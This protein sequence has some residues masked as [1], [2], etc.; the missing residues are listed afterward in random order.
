[1]TGIRRVS[2]LGTTGESTYVDGS[3][4]AV[5]IAANA[6]TQDKLS[7]DV[8]LSGMRNVLINGDM[9]I[10]QRSTSVAI[11]T[12]GYTADRWYHQSYNGAVISQQPT[13]DSTRLPSTRY[14]A[15]VLRNT[16]ATAVN[17]MYFTQSMETSQSVKLAGQTATLSFWARAGAGITSS[18]FTAS[19][20]YGTGTDQNVIAG[21]TGQATAFTNNVTLTTTWQKFTSTGAVP[22]TATEVAFVCGY[23]PVGTAPANDYFEITNVQLEVGPQPTPFEQR[24][25]GME[26]ALCQRY[27]YQ[28]QEGGF[29]RL[30]VV[31]AATTSREAPFFFPVTMRATPTVTITGGTVY[32]FS[33]GASHTPSSTTATGLTPQGGFQISSGM[34]AGT[35]G[36]TCALDAFLIKASA[37]L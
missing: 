8:P 20:I 1:M 28:L 17:F 19:I 7:T 11:A 22:T 21:Y 35:A 5:D 26:L 2:Q 3:I 13:S 10:W 15:R 37:E 23:T 18:T 16:G 36:A 6:V 4:Q 34:A 33:T 25:I 9:N 27:Y 14:C 31:P 24:P 29:N 30:G 32:I 12:L